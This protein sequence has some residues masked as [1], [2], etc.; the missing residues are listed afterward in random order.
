MACR[1]LKF[2][3][4]V[5][6]GEIP[7]HFTP[8]DVNNTE[9]MG[10]MT[11]LHWLC[12]K[13]L[14]CHP[15]EESDNLDTIKW[16]LKQGANTDTTTDS[17][18]Y[19]PLHILSLGSYPEEIEMSSIWT[20]VKERYGTG[21]I[22][23]NERLASKNAVRLL[24]QNG[25]RIIRNKTHHLTP[26]ELFM[27]R[28]ESEQMEIETIQEIFPVN[29]IVR[30]LFG[31]FTLKLCKIRDRE[32]LLKIVS[33]S[34]KHGC[35]YLGNI[36][37]NVSAMTQ[38]FAGKCDLFIL[39]FSHEIFKGRLL[40]DYIPLVLPLEGQN[41]NEIFPLKE[42]DL[43][44]DIRDVS[45]VYDTFG[46][47]GFNATLNLAIC[48]ESMYISFEDHLRIYLDRMGQLAKEHSLECYEDIL[49]RFIDTS[50]ER[51]RI[52]HSSGFNSLGAACLLVLL[53]GLA[54]RCQDRNMAKQIFSGIIAK[55]QM[56]FVLH[57]IIDMCSG[58]RT[59]YRV[60]DGECSDTL[61]HFEWENRLEIIFEFLEAQ[62]NNL[63]EATNTCL[64]VAINNMNINLIT[65]LLTHNAYPYA[66][67]RDGDTC[68]D[69]I[70]R[71]VTNKN[72]GKSILNK[73]IELL[74]SVPPML[75]VLTADIIIQC[76]LW[77]G[78]DSLPARAR[79]IL[80]LHGYRFSLPPGQPL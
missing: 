15:S 80:S 53:E 38:L 51:Y 37:W 63:D 26:L 48:E 23:K 2:N 56:H 29:V 44:T 64:H 30:D 50:I 5:F 72:N 14:Y 76:G 27:L 43:L 33:L 59:N 71:K 45:R 19:T 73:R 28:L 3:Q 60:A 11:P 40:P 55:Y 61:S 77:I 13:Q 4:S 52:K 54:C 35:W 36:E 9:D 67:N 18:G 74:L 68:I 25:A 57:R 78:E 47:T 31:L 70:M 20:L 62:I 32:Q 8:C 7:H 1:G 16:L 49:Y 10:G 21:T 58:T 75:Q 69:L 17:L 42:M 46:V 79:N 41:N 24:L 6:S 22:E 65:E 34:V 12:V 39:V 66:K